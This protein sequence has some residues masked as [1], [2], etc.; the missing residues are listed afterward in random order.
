MKFLNLIKTSISIVLC[1]FILSYE[2]GLAKPESAIFEKAI[3]K[4]IGLPS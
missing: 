4:N 2:L 1:F 3:K